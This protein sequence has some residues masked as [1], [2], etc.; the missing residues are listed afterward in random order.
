VTDDRKQ[1]ERQLR[2]E[3]VDRR[4]IREALEAGQLGTLAVEIALGG[5]RKHTLTE[6]SRASN[7]PA[8][9]LRELLHAL[10][11]PDPRRGE[12]AFTGEDVELARMAR[13]LADAGLPRAEL[14]VAART[15]S[16]CMSQTAEA[17]RHLVGD[18]LLEPG[19]S[20]PALGRRY[21]DAVEDLG[22][23]VMPLLE[24]SLRA[25]LRDGIRREI[26]TEAERED[27]RLAETRDVAVAFADLVGYTKLGTELSPSELGAVAGRFGSLA[28]AAARQP[29]RL[30]KIV[31][32][33]AMFVGQDVGEV[34]A[35]VAD[36]RERVAA[37]DGDLPEL[38]IGVAYGPATPQS[39]DW[40]GATVNLAN[41]ITQVAR[42]GQLLAEEQ[43][44]ERVGGSAWRRRRRRSLK[45]F[46]G[47]VR[48]LSYETGGAA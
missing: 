10:G 22:P 29:V 31:G 35:T 46:E 36:L 32:D 11:R 40:F 16:Q 34:V 1:L 5:R 4:T 21:V 2:D 6:L 42:P 13:R 41:R 26:I 39:G 23:M 45:G 8:A 7:L 19:V 17:L 9:Y 15:V 18:A 44:A 33:G 38:R 12:R 20:E 27:G 14:V 25:H 30:V 28:A 47:R 3:G 48:L 24:L 37:C 43:V